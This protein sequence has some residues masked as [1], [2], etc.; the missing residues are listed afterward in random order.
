LHPVLALRVAAPFNATN[1]CNQK[2][3]T[4]EVSEQNSLG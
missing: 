3:T 1:N 2:H 4:R